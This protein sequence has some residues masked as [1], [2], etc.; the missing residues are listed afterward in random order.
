MRYV[1]VNDRGPRPSR[2]LVL[3]AQVGGDARLSSLDGDTPPSRMPSPGGSLRLAGL[4]GG[5]RGNQCRS[6]QKI[7]IFSGKQCGYCE[8]WAS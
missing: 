4:E 3:S 5:V 6:V 7:L 2:P 8:L 1:T